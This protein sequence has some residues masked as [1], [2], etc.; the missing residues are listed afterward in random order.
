VSIGGHLHR[1]Q[2]DGVVIGNPRRSWSWLSTGAAADT[3]DSSRPARRPPPYSNHGCGSRTTEAT[4]NS[5]A[6]GA[7]SGLG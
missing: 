4:C 5:H 3:M 1:C 6:F 2:S 7:S